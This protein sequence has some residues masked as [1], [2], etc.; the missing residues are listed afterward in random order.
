MSNLSQLKQEVFDYVYLMLGGDIVD[1]E[2]DPK[3]YEMGLTASLSTYR[4]K[5]ANSVEESY[6][7]L[8]L[9]EDKSSYTLDKNIIEVRQIFRRTIGTSQ[10][11]AASFEPFEAGYMNTYLLQS[12]KIGGLASYDLYSGYQ[13]LAAKMFGGHINFTF[14]KV[15]KQLDI[16]RRVRGT[17]EVVML[18]VYNYKPD[19]MLLAEPQCGNWLKDYTLAKCKFMLGEARS[20]FATIAGPQGGTS[21]NGDT[22]KAEAQQEL[23]KLEDDLKYFAD[24]SMPL[25]FIIG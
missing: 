9:E 24:G 10:G 5:A 14:N 3:H 17:G 8:T 19:E 13:E 12:G 22:L 2:L 18:W 6:A 23:Q 1:V 11:S 16:V 4:Q 20:K 25:S 7:F 15:T 21:L